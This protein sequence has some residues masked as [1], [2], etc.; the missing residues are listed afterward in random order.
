VTDA[1]ANSVPPM[2][3]LKELFNPRDGPRGLSELSAATC[4]WV[5]GRLAAPG[6]RVSGNTSEPMP[7][8]PL[9]SRQQRARRARRLRALA[10]A[11]KVE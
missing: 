7:S 11:A 3:V 5:K 4:G 2:T 10:G 6:Q 8:P 1:S 9:A